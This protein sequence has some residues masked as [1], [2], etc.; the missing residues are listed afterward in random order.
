MF[1]R[2]SRCVLPDPATGSVGRISKTSLTKAILVGFEM[3]PA[4]NVARLLGK[5]GN[6][7]KNESVSDEHG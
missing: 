6:E 3:V 7:G 4:T 1:I 2:G 5:F